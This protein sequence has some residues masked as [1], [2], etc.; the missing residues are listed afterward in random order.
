MART[1][2]PK[3]AL[4]TPHGRA[5]IKV[6]LRDEMIRGLPRLGGRVTSSASVSRSA[7]PAYDPA[8]AGPLVVASRSMIRPHP[9]PEPAPNHS[10]ATRGRIPLDEPTTPVPRTNPAL[11][12]DLDTALARLPDPRFYGAAHSVL[13]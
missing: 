13:T 7:D 11:G 8:L 10:G 5:R 6:V 3:I 2:L 12:S 1:I 4:G 9:S